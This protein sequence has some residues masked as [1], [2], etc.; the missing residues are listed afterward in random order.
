MGASEFLGGVRLGLRYRDR[1]SGF[2]GTAV[3]RADYLYDAPTALLVARTDQAP[4]DSRWVSEVRLELCPESNA[5]FS[6]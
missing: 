1:V 4:S 2:V 6:S 3:G 5:G